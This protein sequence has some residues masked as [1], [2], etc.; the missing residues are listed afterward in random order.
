MTVTLEHHTG[1]VVV[2]RHVVKFVQDQ[3]YI[4]LFFDKVFHPTM[5]YTKLPVNAYG[6]K[7]IYKITKVEV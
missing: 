5:V 7:D 3:N 4:T 6:V 2:K 1:R